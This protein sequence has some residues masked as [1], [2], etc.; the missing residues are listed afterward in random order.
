MIQLRWYKTVN[1]PEP[2]LQYRQMYNT[3]VYAGMH[4][5]MQKLETGKFEWSEWIDVPM[6]FEE[7]SYERTN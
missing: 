7:F 1:Y 6:V 2:K 3:T 4:T 5:E